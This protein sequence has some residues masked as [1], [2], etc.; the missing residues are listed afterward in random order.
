MPSK[1][2]AAAQHGTGNLGDSPREEFQLAKTSTPSHQHQRGT[3]KHDAEDDP[4][5][6]RFIDEVLARKG[7]Q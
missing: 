6:S 5:R 7:K 3:V 2:T 4:A 1:V